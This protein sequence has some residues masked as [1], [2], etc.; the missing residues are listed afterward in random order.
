MLNLFVPNFIPSPDTQIFF[1]DPMK[2]SFTVLF[3]SWTTDRKV[4]RTSE[5]QL[6]IVSAV[7]VESPKYL[8]IAVLQTAARS[9]VANRAIN[10]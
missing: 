3:A 10:V 7:K 5:Y 9:G 1:N 8:L 4:V 2:N 6:D